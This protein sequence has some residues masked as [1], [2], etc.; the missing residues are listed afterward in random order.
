MTSAAITR[1]VIRNAVRSLVVL[2]GLSS[3]MTVAT[4][5]LSFSPADT[6]VRVRVADI[7]GCARIVMPGAVFAGHESRQMRPWICPLDA[8]EVGMAENAGRVGAL[9]IMAC[10]TG[11]DVTLGQLCVQPSP[12]AYSHQGEPGLAV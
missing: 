1:R 10:R 5:L 12:A 7:A 8:V 6:R 11:L 4:E 2:I 3:L 9:S